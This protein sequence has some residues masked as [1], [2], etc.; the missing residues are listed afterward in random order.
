MTT[1]YVGLGSNMGD[2]MMN[3]ARAVEAIAHLPETHVEQVSDAYESA[4]AYLEDQPSF[5][6]AALQI[7]TS[8]EADA[9][10][11]HLL[12]VEAALGRE[13]TVDNGPRVIDLDL[14]LF[15]DEEWNSDELTLPHPGLLERD[16]VLT[17]LIEIAPDLRLPDGS[18]LVREGVLVGEVAA[19]LGP[20]PDLGAAH[21]AP[22]EPVNWVVVASS[23]TTA[24]RIVGFDASLQLKHEV[25]TQEGVPVAWEP[26][27]PGADIDPFGMET[28][29]R[30][31]V[32]EH[33]RDRATSVLEAIEQAE[34]EYPEGEGE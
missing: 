2:R 12:D 21:D 16:F 28:V 15:G 25:L 31:L 14:L 10:L 4:P 11:G 27:E 24:D 17:P 22:I 34:P 33:E 20:I 9:L 18:A 30:L 5:L 32:P 6:N 29:Y 23:E 3:L 26:R 7:T 13:K 8:L 19:D 1:A